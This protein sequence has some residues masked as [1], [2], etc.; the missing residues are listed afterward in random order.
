[1]PTR[2][3]IIVKTRSSA[4]SRPRKDDKPRADRLTAG[5]GNTEQTRPRDRRD[6]EQKGPGSASADVQMTADGGT[7]PPSVNSPKG[8]T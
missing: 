2:K 8:R 6:E 3:G 7:E 1:M 4:P 5:P